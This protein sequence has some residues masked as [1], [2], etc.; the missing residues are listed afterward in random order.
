M[1]I[2]RQYRRNY[3]SNLFGGAGIG[4]LVGLSPIVGPFAIGMAVAS[5][6]IIKQVEEYVHKLQIIFALLFFLLLLV[7]KSTYEEL[8]LRYC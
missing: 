4:A 5:T 7:H 8:I 1:E 3:K 6:R 2:S